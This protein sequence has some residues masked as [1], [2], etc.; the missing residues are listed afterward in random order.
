MSSVLR[1][2]LGQVF[3][4]LRNVAPHP[5]HV[6]KRGFHTRDNMRRGYEVQ[7]LP[8][9]HCDCGPCHR[10]QDPRSRAPVPGLPRRQGVEL[11]ADLRGSRDERLALSRP[12]KRHARGC[13][14]IPLH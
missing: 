3:V 13:R 14:R 9:T 10:R 5:A 8:M 2:V 6:G 7:Q 4:M 11:R 1:D 12:I